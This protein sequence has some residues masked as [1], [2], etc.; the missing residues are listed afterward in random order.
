M[1]AVN[2]YSQGPNAQKCK[3]TKNIYVAA[4]MTLCCSEE[5]LNAKHTMSPNMMNRQTSELPE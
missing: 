1:G 5:I 3:V 4:V 2:G